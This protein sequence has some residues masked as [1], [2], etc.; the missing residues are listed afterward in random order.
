MPAPP[1]RPN[2]FNLMQFL[3][4]FGKIPPLLEGS[5]PTWAKSWIVSDQKG[6]R[7]L[8]IY[9]GFTLYSGD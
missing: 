9:V 7:E 2:S 1:G 6:S 5:C 3:G 4:E 8:D